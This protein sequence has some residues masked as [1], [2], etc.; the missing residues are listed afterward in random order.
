VG[1]SPDHGVTRCSFAAATATPGV[2]LEDPAGQDRPVWLETLSDDCETELVEA[3]ER[4]QVR[5][6]EG[7][8]RHGEVIR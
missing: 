4:G 5:A 2:G 6:S 1:Q 7:S 8:V 3:A